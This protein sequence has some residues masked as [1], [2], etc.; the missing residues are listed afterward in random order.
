MKREDEE[1]T[2]E[3]EIQDL[4]MTLEKIRYSNGGLEA[5]RRKYNIPLRTSNSART[6]GGRSAAGSS[7]YGSNRAVSNGDRVIR[8]EERMVLDDEEDEGKEVDQQ[9]DKRM[10]DL[11]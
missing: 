6:N 8:E 1:K 10:A 4:R 9:E 11:D 7:N 2:L 3:D 5:V